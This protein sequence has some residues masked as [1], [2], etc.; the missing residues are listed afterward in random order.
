MYLLMIAGEALCHGILLLFL[1]SLYP[2]FFF[3]QVI[4]RQVQ[5]FFSALIICY[6][7][8]ILSKSLR[9]NIATINHTDLKCFICYMRATEFVST[10]ISDDL[11]GTCDNMSAQTFFL[12]SLYSILQV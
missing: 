6:L 7:M 3:Y 9:I 12:H 1:I 11:C 4:T 8:V 2:L 10:L 5:L